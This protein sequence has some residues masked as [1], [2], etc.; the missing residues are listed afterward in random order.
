MYIKRTAELT[1]E[2]LGKEFPGLVIYGPRQ[3]GKS[4]LVHFAFDGKFSSVSLDDRD[5]LSLALYNPKLFLESHPW[6]I[7]IDEI[8]K[9]P[10]LLS[11]IKSEIDKAKLKWL[12]EGKSSSLMYVLTG[13][14]QFSLQQGVSESLAGRI[15]VV[16][17]SSMSLAEKEG[18]E[19]TAFVP[20]LSLLRKKE[21]QGRKVFDRKEIF[22]QIFVGGR[23]DVVCGN[24]SREDYFKSYLNTYLE[25]DVRKLLS[26]D[27][28][29]TFR[30]FRKYV[31]FRTGQEVRYDDLSSSVGIDVKTV[32]RWLSI[33]ETSGIIAFL[34]PF[35]KNASNRIIK[36]PKR[37]F[38]DTGLAAFLCGWPSPERLEQC[39]MAGAFFETFVVSERIKS[40]LFQGK[41]YRQ[42]LYYYRD[43][44]QKEIDVL[45]ERNGEIYPIEIKKGINP[46]K[47]N[48]N[49]KV[50]SKYHL[51]IKTGFI[52]DCTD[53]IRPI[54]ANV[55]TLPIGLIE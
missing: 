7:S 6:P 5:E 46:T 38:M 24:V 3:C 21:A 49:F 50:L 44:D 34:H 55:Y 43:I 51:P 14:N 36:A 41:D 33:L 47:P 10:N 2:R 26:A 20:D 40:F 37:Y 13:S 29:T 54:N 15:G 31:A 28:E 17:L 25:K 23:P 52:I 18:W 9:A 35:R 27:N 53:K 4:T 48:K 32:K 19:G 12:K 45:Y 8:Q 39:A 42:T 11:A 1:L 30:V 22:H 16:E